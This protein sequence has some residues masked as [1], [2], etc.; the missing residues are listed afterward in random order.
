LLSAFRNVHWHRWLRAKN[1]RRVE[2]GL[3]DRGLVG[4]ALYYDAQTDDARLV[5]ATVRS[6][7]RAGALAAN[8]VEMTALLKPDGRVRGAAVR[9]VLTGETANIRAHVVVNATGP[10]SDRVRR[11]DDP[12]AAPIMRPTKGAHVIVPR[13]RLA[14]EHAVTLFSPVDGRVMFALPWGDL[15]YIGTTDTDADA[16]PDGLRVTAADVTYLLR[17]A[18]AAFP[19][20]HLAQSDVLSAWA[21]LRPLLREDDRNP[22]QVTREHRVLESPQGLISIVGGKLTTYRVMARDVVD[23]VAAR[24]HE[25]DGRPRA[26]R[27]P[28]DRQPLPGG[29]AAE[30]DVL[31]ESAR[32]RGAAEATARHLVANYGSEAAAVLNLVDRE[33]RLGESL[34]PGRPEIW[35]EVVYAVEREMAVR[36]QDVLI[37]RLHLF[38]EVADHGQSVVP[39]VTALMKQRLG[40]DDA[41]EAEEL[42]D[43]FQLVERGRITA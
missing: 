25:L 15:S 33:R 31:V 34:M 3:R 38:Y 17:S 37:R 1:V 20:A 32:A 9:D 18:N 21:G 35:A 6:A 29:E 16:S 22:S 40:W 27:P 2:P 30:L 26:K 24:L 10:W 41:R 36:V 19:D 28:T 39:R 11:L 4:A 5:I 42:R 8:Y 12:K 23:R 7:V 13:K 14:N 43:Y